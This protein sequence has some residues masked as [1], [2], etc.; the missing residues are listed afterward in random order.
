MNIIFLLKPKA[1]VA[2]LYSGSTLRK[3]LEKMK[4][5]GYTAIPVITREGIYA[6]TVSEGDFLWHMI[7][8]ENFDMKAQE[9]Y[10]IEDIIRKGWNPAVKITATMDDLFLRVTEQNFVPVVDDRNAFM[11]IITRKD[12]IK[13]Y[14][15]QARGESREFPCEK[16]A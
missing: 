4:V 11:G 14:Y 5:H 7:S 16:E 12:V 9:E 3:G 10:Q 8:H 1:T 6:G 2:Y 13:Y 15:D